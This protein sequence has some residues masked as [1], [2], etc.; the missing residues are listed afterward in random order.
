MNRST[1]RSLGA[2]LASATVTVSGSPLAANA[3]RGKSGKRSSFRDSL[4]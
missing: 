3:Q 2:A 1:I 4:V